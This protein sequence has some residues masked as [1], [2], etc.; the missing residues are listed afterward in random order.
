MSNVGTLC[1]YESLLIELAGG[2]IFPHD[3]A[4]IIIPL[5]VRLTGSHMS[6]KS[7]HIYQ[8]D[9]L[10]QR[11]NMAVLSTHSVSIQDYPVNV[12]VRFLIAKEGNLVVYASD[13][14]Q[15][16]RS[17]KKH[18]K[19]SLCI[20][21]KQSERQISTHITVL[22]MAKVGAIDDQYMAIF[23]QV[24]LYIQSHDFRFYLVVPGQLTVK[25]GSVNFTG[26]ASTIGKVICL[27][28]LKVR[29]VSL[30]ICT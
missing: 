17:M 19:I 24:E 3:L 15:Y 26:L 27:V 23:P 6:N 21:G 1:E 10:T 25:V 11:Q 28:G 8:A 29:K 22:G 30:G 7:Y 9:L 13:I 14:A 20:Y 5:S 4:L 16:F 12:V 2:M 18:H